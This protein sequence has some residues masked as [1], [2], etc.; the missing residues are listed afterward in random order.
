MSL[1]AAKMLRY[2][3]KIAAPT[4]KAQQ[5]V[6]EVV[7]AVERARDSGTLSAR[8]AQQAIENLNEVIGLQSDTMVKL[9]EIF[10]ALEEATL[11]PVP[12]PR[13]RSGQSGFRR[14]IRR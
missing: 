8:Q 4:E 9:F 11:P 3:E 10:E 2:G 12:F 1:T 7:R 5:G 6:A 13:T 14:A